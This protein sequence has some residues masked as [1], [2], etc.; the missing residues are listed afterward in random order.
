MQNDTDVALK[1]QKS[2]KEKLKSLWQ[3]KKFQ[4]RF[5]FWLFLLPVTIPFLLMVITPFIMGIYYSFTDWD[6]FSTPSW[7]GLE[8]YRQLTEDYRFVYSFY[9][10]IIYS[11]LNV[12]MINLVAF[13][14]ALLVTRKLKLTNLYRAGFFMPNLIGGLIIGYLWRFIFN[15]ALGS[16]GLAL[17][18]SSPVNDTRAMYALV[19]VVTWQYAGYIMMIYVAALLNVPEDLIEA[20]Q[21]DGANAFQRLRNITLPLVA[22][23][24]TVAMFLTLT[25]AFKQFDT[26]VSLTRGGGG[27]RLPEFIQGALGMERQPVVGS[28]SLLTYNIFDWGWIR[29]NLAEAQSQAVAFFLVLAVISLGQVYFNKKREVEL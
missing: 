27:E 29:G 17:F 15:V 18:S 16:E 13:G 12:I 6:G 4:D 11:I 22:Q 25:T 7:V 2:F 3:D 28:T 1:E 26:V 10:T 20:S 23:A 9:R 5:W 19:F 21:I 24:F 14:L 8:N